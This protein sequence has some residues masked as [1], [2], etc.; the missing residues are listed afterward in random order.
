[1][2]RT[3]DILQDSTMSTHAGEHGAAVDSV[4]LATDGIVTGITLSPPGQ[5]ISA[6]PRW[7]IRGPLRP[8]S[9]NGKS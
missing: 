7:M 3:S 9:L 6:S 8:I 2:G 4:I 1:M 5:R